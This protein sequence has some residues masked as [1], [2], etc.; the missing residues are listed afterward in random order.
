MSD[1]WHWFIIVG[2]IASLAFFLW[3]LMVNRTSEGG[4]TGHEWDGIEELDNPLPAWW[5][6]M[7]IITIV[8]ALIYMVIFPGLGNFSGVTDWTSASEH[9]TRAAA[10]SARFDDLYDHLASLSPE[11]LADDVAGMQVGRRLFINNCS[12]CHG[13]NAGGAPGFPDLS[14]DH[15]IWGGSFEAI[16]AS[17]DS[18]RVAAMPPWG[19][20]L[21]NDG[22]TNVANFVLQMAGQPHDSERATQGAGQYQVFCVSCHGPNG[23][24]N[25][26]LGAPRITDANTWIYGTSL[27]DVAET[28]RAGRQG[29]MPAFG[30]LIDA[31]QRKIIATYVQSL[32]HAG[33]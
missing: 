16:S 14:D 21:G 4:T 28:I 33:Q 6:W 2:T 3:L 30:D 24:G 12:T 1:F 9:D 8:F 23:H 22:V 10:H 15:W 7:F 31:R 27:E 29:V 20:A 11:E 17:I 32:S 13:V 19:P 26:A 25:P 18:G 5:V